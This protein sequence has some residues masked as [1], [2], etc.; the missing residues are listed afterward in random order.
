[1]RRP[2]FSLK[3][4]G[5]GVY[6]LDDGTPAAPGVRTNQ[7]QH[8]MLP[9]YPWLD[10]LLGAP[11]RSMSSSATKTLNAFSTTLITHYPREGWHTAI[12]SARPKDGR[13]ASGDFGLPAIRVTMSNSVYR[14]DRMLPPCV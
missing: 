7:L 14:F 6:L 11:S 4:F 3:T 13:L 1:M 5:P 9:K 8:R 12:R 2:Q 10:Y